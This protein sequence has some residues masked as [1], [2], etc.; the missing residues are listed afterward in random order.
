MKDRL[1]QPDEVFAL[2]RSLVGRVSWEA[3][4]KGKGFQKRFQ[5][6]WMFFKKEALKGAVAGDPHV[7]N[8]EPARRI[9]RG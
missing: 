8:E 5:K 3:D 4:P 2:L 9:L 7:L 6:D 1:A